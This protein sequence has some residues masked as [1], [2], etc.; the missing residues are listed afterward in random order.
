MDLKRT[1]NENEE[2]YLWRLGQA[3]DAGLIDIDWVG[4]A[5]LM[6][7]EFREDESVYR[8]E[9]AYRKPYQYAKKMYEAGVFKQYEQDSYIED[10]AATKDEIRK[11]KQ[12]LFDERK[13]LNK[14]T[15]SFA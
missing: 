7:K 14:R 1:E 9:S 3:K 2:Q 4:I 5:D 11:E 8:N 6:N 12:K 10:L 15:E 13:A